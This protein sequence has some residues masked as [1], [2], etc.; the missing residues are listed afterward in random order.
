[1]TRSIDNDKYSAWL[2][3]Y[4]DDWVGTQCIADD[5]NTFHANHNHA[6]TH[7]G[8]PCNGE[9]P[10]NPLYRFCTIERQEALSYANGSGGITEAFPVRSWQADFSANNQYSISHNQG[11]HEYIT[12]DTNRLL[13]GC[14]YEGKAI[15]RAPQTFFHQ[16]RI[17][18]GR[19]PSG[20]YDDSYLE[21]ATT[22]T[23]GVGFMWI[24]NARS[25]TGKYWIP[26]DNDGSYI[27]KSTKDMSATET[28][29]LSDTIK[30]SAAGSHLSF[31]IP[32]GGRIGR[33]SYLTG[34]FQ[35]QSMH[36]DSTATDKRDAVGQEI[37]SLGGKSFMVFDIKRYARDKSSFPTGTAPIVAYEGTLNGSGDNDVFHIRMCEQSLFGARF[38]SSAT[39]TGATLNQN[40]APKLK[41]NVGFLESDT[42]YSSA[43]ITA[44]NPAISVVIDRY[45]M[46]L[47][48]TYANYSHIATGLGDNDGVVPKGTDYH[49]CV[50]KIG[51]LSGTTKEEKMN[52]LWYD[53][54]IKCDFTNQEYQVYVNGVAYGSATSFQS[55][56]GG[57]SWSAT[58]FYGWELQQTAVSHSSLTTIVSTEGCFWNHIVMIDR[59][60]FGKYITH[61][62]TGTTPLLNKLSTVMTS[63]SLQTS[64]VEIY[65]DDNVLNL[66]PLITGTANSDYHFLL[67]RNGQDRPILNGIVNTIDIKQQMKQNTR[68]IQMNITDPAKLLDKNLP[69]FDLG[70][71]TLSSDLDV[72]VG[73]RGAAESLQ[74]ALYFGTA[75]LLVRDDNI[76]G[77]QNSNSSLSFMPTQDQRTCLGSSHPIQL[78]N[79]EDERGPNYPEYQWLGKKAKVVHPLKHN[80]GSGVVISTTVT[81]IAADANDGTA[82]WGLS[83]ASAPEGLQTG[84]TVNLF[85]GSSGL[86]LTNEAVTQ[87]TGQTAAD[88]AA[89]NFCITETPPNKNAEVDKIFQ[90]FNGT[91]RLTGLRLKAGS[92]TG[93]PHQS[94]ATHLVLKSTDATIRQ[95]MD[96]VPVKILNCGYGQGADSSNYYIYTDADWATYTGYATSV[97][98]L[99][100]VPGCTSTSGVGHV[101]WGDTYIDLHTADSSKATL[102]TFNNVAPW[103]TPSVKN[104]AA[105]AV[106][107]RDFPKSLWFKKMFGRIAEQPAA[108][109]TLQSPLPVNTYSGTFHSQGVLT[110]ILYSDIPADMISNGGVAELVHPN[111]EVDSFCFGTVSNASTKAQLNNCKFITH[112]YQTNYAIASVA[113]T[114]NLR[115]ISDDYKHIWVLWS[116]MRNDGNADADGVSR[117][118]K[119][120]LLYPTP[121]NYSVSLQYTDQV[122]IDGSPM[123]FVDLKVGYDCD[124]WEIDAQKEPYTENAWSTLGS[125][126]YHDSEFHNWESKA[127]SFLIFDFSKFFNLNTEANGGKCNQIAG[128]RKTLG[129]LVIDTEGHPALIDDYWQEVVASPK[130]MGLSRNDFSFHPNWYNFFSS[131]SN[132]AAN[133]G[134]APNI[135]NTNQGST[136]LKL[137]DTSE[138][139]SQGIGMIELERDSTQGGTKERNLLFFVWFA[140]N[141]STN[142]LQRVTSFDL[143]ETVLTQDDIENQMFFYYRSALASGAGSGATGMNQELIYNDSI[144][145]ITRGYEKIVVYSSLSAPFALRFMMKL[146]G[147]IESKDK[148]TWYIHDAIRSMMTLSNTIHP[149]SLFRLPITFSK[150]NIPITRRMTTTQQ[151]VNVASR[152]Y[153]NNSGGT[154]DWDNFGGVVDVRGKSLLQGIV[155]IAEKTRV[156]TENSTTI[157]TWTTGKD[158]R[159]DLRPAYSS[160]F[161]FTRDNLSVSNITGTPTA[162]ISN[163][164]VFYNNGASFI[165]YPAGTPGTEAK[166]KFVDVPTVRSD[167]EA[168]QIAKRTYEQSKQTN[169]SINAEFITQATE[170][171]KMLYNARFGYIADPALRT[172][173]PVLKDAQTWTSWYNGI[174]Y[175]GVQNRLD[176]N[177]SWVGFGT[178]NAYNKRSTGKEVSDYTNNP[179][180][181][182]GG[183]CVFPT[184]DVAPAQNYGWI[185]DK[186]LTNAVEIVHIP[187]GMPKVSDAHGHELR[188]SIQLADYYEVSDG[189][190]IEDMEFYI[191]LADVD[192]SFTAGTT[193]VGTAHSFQPLTISEATPDTT[194]LKFKHSGFHELEIPSGYWADETGNERIVVSIDA[195]YLRACLRQRMGSKVGQPVWGN[196]MQIPGAPL[197]GGTA[198]GGSSF[199]MGARTQAN[200]PTGQDTPWYHAPR[201]VIVDDLNFYPSTKV[202]Y[203]D[204]NIGINTATSFSIKQVK[205]EANERNHDKVS[206]VLE[207]DESKALD[208][209]AK[210][211]LP[212]INKG[213]T[214]GTIPTKPAPPPRPGGS[215]GGGGDSGYRPEVPPQIGPVGTPFSN[216]HANASIPNR[217]IANSN[218]GVRNQPGAGVDAGT[219]TIS[220]QMLSQAN[221]GINNTTADLIKRATGNMDFHGQFGNKD[222][223]FNFLGQKKK[224]AP[225]QT[226]R[227]L[228]GID[229]VWDKNR[230]A[231]FSSE[232]A[233]FPGITASD[234]G[235][236]SQIHAHSLRATVPSDV[237][238][239]K[240]VLSGRVF[241]EADRA[242]T[243][244]VSLLV[245]LECVETGSSITK[246]VPVFGGEDG[247]YQ[248]AQSVDITLLSGELDGAN[249]EGNTIKATIKRQSNFGYDDAQYHSLILNNLKMKFVRSAV[250]GRSDS[251]RFLGLKSGGVRGN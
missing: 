234:A 219:T 19:S 156:G 60:A 17:N 14:F 96:N 170:T 178:T 138:F 140:K 105:Q 43:G 244:G 18:L 41:L 169:V 183:A 93:L 5:S 137:E 107:M 120:G 231:V 208:G 88:T 188:V 111:G 175:S 119:F 66:Y 249:V 35:W 83:G 197:Y 42:A 130:N 209:L 4:Y 168:A 148:G 54:D 217:T 84:D 246:L 222:G 225:A 190:D 243:V 200:I 152:L 202:T 32:T 36:Q 106:W 22:I 132:L 97:I 87:H 144:N 34:M 117:V 240:V 247:E 127:G 26:A 241:M 121:D 57:G 95:V 189:K 216:P 94:Q 226:T 194:S 116:D 193:T 90:Y 215:G 141:D 250:S 218:E 16:N 98:N 171:D 47:G 46:S 174:H 167:K 77:E 229:C 7:A 146:N 115:T 160:G 52:N 126:S 180:S 12:K 223:E 236:T 78:Y 136:D 147:Y 92:F 242:G 9:A 131:G 122:N 15:P 39:T 62:L 24:N 181:N 149:L 30:H 220:G 139:P 56:P 20:S 227:E 157:F 185:G 59:V 173:S 153:K 64:R 114:I 172:C 40:F 206:L 221:V 118:N 23:N 113:P 163:V 205:W 85:G 224:G 125:N 61:P 161:V 51:T 13:S 248:S 10:L 29:Y 213:R 48:D 179:Q 65:D 251:Y 50:N 192:P 69:V 112:N 63:N 238:G 45:A 70:Q 191:T 201:I 166:W 177:I 133:T 235:A 86:S 176:G 102:T 211:I 110:N 99:S 154:L 79:N 1:M 73:Q 187:K 58:D 6:N 196:A 142:T 104:R 184:G 159:L 204:S 239:K 245:K 214:P 81:A 198:D 101:W 49:F 143:D 207:R 38:G 199:P 67:F 80:P 11:I 71:T 27:R 135:V 164:R 232:G 182:Y 8:N 100:I 53:I 21:N 91:D 124:I 210:Y 233:V 28:S 162:N 151:A 76:G 195:E 74:D 33:Q 37:T 89:N 55:K 25:T 212:E 75:K 129:D 44:T 109:G 155:E 103:T 68:I 134:S 230:G 72:A 145:G 123:D 3:G 237:I 31:T 2:V 186:S 165:D 158:G 128:R 82:I 108:S 150:V 228:D 203:T